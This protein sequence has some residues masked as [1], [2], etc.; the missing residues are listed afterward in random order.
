MKKVLLTI[1]M[2][3][4]AVAA[5]AQKPVAGDYTA[6][7]TLNPSQL[8][9]F[10]PGSGSPLELNGGVNLRGRYFLKDNMAIRGG[11]NIGTDKDKMNFYQNPD[12]S[13]NKGSF[14][15]NHSTITLMPGI[16][17]HHAGG[18]KLSTYCG[19]DLLISMMSASSKGENTNAAGNAYGTYTTSTSGGMGSGTGI[20]LRAVAGFD[21]YILEKIY[22]GAEL[23]WGYRTDS[24]KDKTTTMKDGAA[25][26]VKT[27][28]AGGSN[29]G[30]KTFINA[31]F[32]LGWRF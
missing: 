32:R 19:A 10:T 6:E 18:E 8:G 14:T 27:I 23:G 25:A 26:E 28:E 7:M 15:M 12:G 1:T 21:Y 24:E 11:L 9:I 4:F 2:A 20:G 31:G 16:E 3:A 30:L 22:L 29:G 13:G 5:Y 17:M